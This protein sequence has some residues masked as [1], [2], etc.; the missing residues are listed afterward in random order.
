[1][2]AEYGFTGEVQLSLFGLPSGVTAAFTPNPTT[3]SS[4]LRLTASS[5]ASL[6]EC[7][8]TLTG[9]SGSQTL[10][11]TFTL[12]VYVPTFTVGTSSYVTLGQGNSISTYV[13]VNPA[14][15]F[16]GNVQFGISGLPSG[17]TASFSPNPATSSS[18]LKLTAA[19]S[20]PTGQ[21]T[22]TVTG[23]SGSQSASASI[24][25]GVFTPTFTLGAS[26]NLTI[27]PGESGQVYIGIDELYGFSGNI[28]LAVS[29]LPSG[30]TASFSPNPATGY[31][32][33]NF[34]VGS[35]VA[36]GEYTLTV[37]GTSGAQ[38]ASTNVDLIVN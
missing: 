1:M 18:L 32:Y 31:S 20:A 10:S 22:I 14:Y 5:A 19:S 34:T 26:G 9:T 27:S 13:G 28:Q 38:K 33:L 8:V 4:T 15:G 37:E 30:V 7:I 35:S 29:G 17:V 21:Y 6:G 12:G 2:N 36:P 24:T 16:T 3:N 11:T 25:L 23:M